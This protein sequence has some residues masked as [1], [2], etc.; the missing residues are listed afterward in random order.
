MSEWISASER[1]QF[2][3]WKNVEKIRT[4]ET[5]ED[6]VSILTRFRMN[7]MEEDLR[8]QAAAVIQELETLH[9]LLRGREKP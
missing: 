9:R 8:A 7:V 5:V 3:A 1:K 2:E 6:Y 4:A